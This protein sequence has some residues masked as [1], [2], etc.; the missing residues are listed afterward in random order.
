M[1]LAVI[2]LAEAGKLKE[3]EI[4]FAH[5]LIDRYLEI[6]SIIKTDSDHPNP[7]FPF[8]HLRSEKFWLLEARQ[9]REVILNAI[10]T[11]R[12]YR[13]I[14]DNIAFARLDDG[15]YQLLGDNT[16]RDVLRQALIT[17][18]FGRFT[19]PLNQLA[20]QDTYENKL[21]NAVENEKAVAEEQEAYQKPARYAAFRRI[22]IEA[23][24]YRCAA[25]GHRIVL[26]GEI[27]MVEAA[28]LIPFSETRD[29]DPR[30]G[31]ALT[32]N[33]HWALDRIIISPGPDYKWHVSKSVDKKIADNMPLLELNGRELLL[34]KIKQFWP[35]QDA[36]ESRL[37]VLAQ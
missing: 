34:P 8:F 31:I 2:G 19:R 37:S 35:R 6:F 36:L 18:W 5:P 29:D 12:S 25:S 20:A 9:A 22:V 27:I 33:F 30:N 3:N 24:D 23:Y 10:S 28:H 7:Y 11:A 4:H 17:R 16:A 32:P 1:L 15:L 13:Q 21:R 26:P 14:E